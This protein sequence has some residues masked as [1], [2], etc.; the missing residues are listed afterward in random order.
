MSLIK[1][2]QDKPFKLLSIFG[3]IYLIFTI[4]LNVFTGFSYSESILPFAKLISYVAEVLVLV[5]FV[6]TFFFCDNHYLY[7]VGVEILIFSNLYAGRIYGALFL[8][9]LLL[10]LLVTEKQI[11]TLKN[12]IIYIGLEIAKL[13]LVIQYGVAD[14]FNYVGLSLFY[15][16]TIGCMNLL[17]RH[18]YSKKENTSLNLDDYKF[19]DRQKDCIKEIVLNNITIKALALNHNVSESAIKKDLANIYTELGITGKADLKALFIDYKF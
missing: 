1:K 5:L 7:Y 8:S 16:C 3:C 18:A 9:S 12:L 15:L 6:L 19:T 14:F 11:F 10:V 13:G 17:F 2:F 4:L